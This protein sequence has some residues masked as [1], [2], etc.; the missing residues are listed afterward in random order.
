[1]RFTK[2]HWILLAMI[3]V[4]FLI[5][6]YFYPKMPAQIASHWN[7]RGEADDYLSKFWGLFLMPMISGLFF[8]VFLIIPKIDPLKA[9]YQNFK[10]YFDWFFVFLIGFFLY[11]Y[12]I[13][14]A[15]N[16]G[17]RFNM[18]IFMVPALAVLFFYVGVLISHAQRNW[19]VGIRTPWTLSNEVVWEKT[20][21]LGGLL[22]KIVGV[23]C[24]LG[25][26]FE[27]YAFW[28]IIIPVILAGLY[29]VV[30]SYLEY[31]KQMK[32]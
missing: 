13:S 14:I 20:H 5:G 29:L 2:V 11:I 32:A 23:V 27:P 19:F 3:L 1:M 25:I 6:I 9:N 30:Y 4:S 18:T 31:Q 26:L 28:L 8:L 7:T 22:F 24:L 16:L 15:W 17:H 12:L 21:K 10:K